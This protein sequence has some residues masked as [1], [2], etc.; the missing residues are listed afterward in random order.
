MAS[1]A[2]LR[3]ARTRGAGLEFQEYR[4]Y[5]P[6]DDPRSIDWGVEARLDQLVV[7]VSRA[8]GDLRVHLLVD[9]SASMG[10]GVPSKLA[11]AT[12]AAAAL[13]YVAIERRDA[14]GVTTFS[15]SLDSVAKPSA[16]RGQL[17]R[18][19]EQLSTLSPRGTSNLDDAL[20]RCGAA[21]Q[22]PGLVVVLS[23]FF[24]PAAGVNGL[25]YLLHRGLTPALVQILAPEE[26]HPAV[27]DDT[28]LIDVEDE[29]G[30]PLLVDASALATYHRNL[31]RHEEA[32]R[33]FCAAQRVPWIRLTS[34][35]PFR[36]IVASV[37]AAGLFTAV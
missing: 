5:Q 33:G 26:R 13:S 23:D 30:T 10:L 36:S 6:G 1:A 20:L 4:H 34:D 17:F 24:M 16:G 22:G 12:T 31:A 19:L 29:G 37:Q 3:R 18:S 32:L 7:R 21:F 25:H 2:G 15:R 14:V 11:C 27:D 9:V 35:A 28:E 8:D